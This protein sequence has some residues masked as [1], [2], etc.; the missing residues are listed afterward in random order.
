MLHA[1]VLVR[2]DAV[3]LV[4]HLAHASVKAI[5]DLSL[6]LLVLVILIDIA[7]HYSRIVVVVNVLLVWR[8]SASLDFASFNF[9]CVVCA[10]A[11]VI[12]TTSHFLF[13]KSTKLINAQ[14]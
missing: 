10:I 1:K 7:A 5:V 2:I 8:S 3:V 9:L 14:I 12:C 4:H 13:I 6:I 11:A